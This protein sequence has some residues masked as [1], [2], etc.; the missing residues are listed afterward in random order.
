MAEVSLR[1][2]KAKQL[3]QWIF[4]ITFNKTRY[5]GRSIFPMW[6]GGIPTDITLMVEK[7]LLTLYD[8][9]CLFFVQ[10]ICP[11]KFKDWCEYSDTKS[12]AKRK[13][14]GLSIL[15]R[16]R[17]LNFRI[18]FPIFYAFLMQMSHQ[19][20]YSKILSCLLWFL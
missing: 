5:I 14:N 20:A 11:T 12:K 2:A 4:L 6:I 19:D 17:V 18:Q 7:V 13:K 9:R 8:G 1:K 3:Q 16:E 15:K 10:K